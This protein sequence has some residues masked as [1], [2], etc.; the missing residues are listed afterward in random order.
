MIWEK[1]LF[2]Q[3]DI[4]R[5]RTRLITILSNKS[6]FARKRISANIFNAF[7]Y[8]HC[9]GDLR[10]LL[11]PQ[12]STY[13]RVRQEILRLNKPTAFQFFLTKSD[14]WICGTVF[15]LALFS[16]VLKF[17]RAERFIEL[18]DFEFAGYYYSHTKWMTLKQAQCIYISI[19]VKGNASINICAGLSPTILTAKNH[20]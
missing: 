15:D 7:V 18:F 4:N 2:G 6:I 13:K 9:S 10:N 3:S 17:T 11:N 1:L 14:L 5:S 8:I 20:S 12:Q 16:R 19:A